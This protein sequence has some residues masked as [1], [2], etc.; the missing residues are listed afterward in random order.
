[1]I[2]AESEKEKPSDYDSNAIELKFKDRPHQSTNSAGFRIV[3]PSIAQW[4]GWVGDWLASET[5]ARATVVADQLRTAKSATRAGNECPLVSLAYCNSSGEIESAVLYVPAKQGQDTATLLCA[6]AVGPSGNPSSLLPL[7]DAL[8]QRWSSEGVKIAF[9]STET[10]QNSLG[11]RPLA[12]L[13]YLQTTVKKILKTTQAVMQPTPVPAESI[14]LLPFSDPSGE[15]VHQC[16]A[17]TYV[18]SLDCAVINQFRSAR[19]TIAGY[20]SSAVYTPRHWYRCVDPSTAEVVGCVLLAMHPVVP[21]ASNIPVASQSDDSQSDDSQSD[22]SQSDDSQSDDSQSDDSQSDDSQADDSAFRFTAEIVYMGLL[23]KHRGRGLGKQIVAEVA[24]TLQNQASQI[25]LAVDRAN[26]P[27][28]DLY[29]S[30]TFTEVFRERLW[31]WHESFPSM[32]K[33][34]QHLIHQSLNS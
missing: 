10:G 24:R 22:D 1:M 29:R 15:D 17:L 13:R 12:E 14:Q 2:G 18:D 26:Q 28:A 23:P 7:A 21:D 19:Q 16:V 9:W 6:G 30:L 5:L 32:P 8:H 11:F 20:Q 33:T 34:D 27:A 25:I 4:N 31:F 3:E